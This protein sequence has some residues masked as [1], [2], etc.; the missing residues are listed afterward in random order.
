MWGSVTHS[1]LPFLSPS[2]PLLSTV[3]L[4]YRSLLL[5]LCYWEGNLFQGLRVDAC[6]TLGNELSKETHM[7]IKQKTLLGRGAGMESH[8]ERVQN[9]GFYCNGVSFPDC[10]WPI[11]L[12]V[13]TLV[14]F[15][16]FCWH[17]HLSIKIVSRVRVSGRLAGYYGL[18]SPP[19]F[20]PTPLPAP[21]FFCLVVACQFCVPYQEYL[22]DNSCKWL[23]SCLERVNDLGQ[24][25]P[26]SPMHVA[27]WLGVLS[28]TS[29]CARHSGRLSKL[30]HWSL[31][32]RKIYH[33]A[34]QREWVACAQ[35]TC[36][37]WWFLGRSFIGKLWDEGCR[38]C[39]FLLIGW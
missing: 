1:N 9:L 22:W 28:N 8:R 14:Q 34:N 27:L 37:P 35:K 6:L 4:L 11:I 38:L 12:L 5:W 33:G 23:L 19:F 18:A 17:V 24:W 39:G 16:T 20:C 13:P 31:K 36:T 29:L 7:L 3:F 26:N 2:W 21:E 25:F 10:L 15:K 30:K 32:Q